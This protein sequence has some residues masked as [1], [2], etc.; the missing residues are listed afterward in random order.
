MNVHIKM[1]ILYPEMKIL[2]T[3]LLM[4]IEKLYTNFLIKAQRKA[5]HLI[6]G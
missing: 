5:M 6:G 3:Y 4:V 1:K 2:L